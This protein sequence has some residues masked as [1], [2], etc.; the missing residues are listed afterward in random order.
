M[1]SA[2]HHDSSSEVT[3]KPLQVSAHHAPARCLKPAA[4]L[5]LH[6]RFSP[7]RM[8]AGSQRGRR[9]SFEE[10][11]MINEAELG[12]EIMRRFKGRIV[13]AVGAAIG[14]G[15]VLGALIF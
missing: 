1:A 11:A 2:R 13:L 8:D 9:E 5:H 3:H 14:V 6:A 10:H 4:P 7:F 15:F 12:T